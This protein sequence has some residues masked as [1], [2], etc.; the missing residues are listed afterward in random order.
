M[1]GNSRGGKMDCLIIKSKKIK[2]RMLIITLMFVLLNVLAVNKILALGNEVTISVHDYGAQGDGVTNDFDAIS[3]AIGACDG[4][5][6]CTVFF[7]SGEYIV[8]NSILISKSNIRLL[9]EDNA[10]I[11]FKQD[12][13]L[14]NK[15]GVIVVRTVNQDVT[16]VVLENLIVNGNATNSNY[17]K[18]ST[19]TLGRGITVIR[20]G[21]YPGTLNYYEMSNIKIKNCTVKNTYTFGIAVLG[22]E[23]LKDGYTQDE[24]NELMDN[25]TDDFDL[26][27]YKNFYDVD[28]VTIENCK[29]SKTRIGIRINRVTNVVLDNNEVSDSRLENITLQVDNATIK[30]NRT[31]QHSG[32]CGSICLDKSDNVTIINNS[33]NDTESSARD[34]DKTGICQNSSAGPSYNVYIANNSIKSNL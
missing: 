4:I 14:T 28:N 8:E 17:G 24:V 13:D 6:E 1:I 33:I 21:K 34:I 12:I 2:C 19:D 31:L 7:P 3:A 27:K 20:Q 30:N 32:G 10:T 9:G 23:Q 18:R 5:T 22:G 26:R 15:P 11:S 25:A 29:V 16:N